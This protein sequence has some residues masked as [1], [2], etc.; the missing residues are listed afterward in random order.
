MEAKMHEQSAVS[1]LLNADMGRVEAEG[2]LL[3]Y[4]DM[5]MGDLYSAV[6]D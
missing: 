5:W 4:G 3:A 2:A 6:R 1:K